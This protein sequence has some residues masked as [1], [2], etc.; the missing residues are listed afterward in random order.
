MGIVAAAQFEWIDVDRFGGLIEEA[1]ESV[2][3]LRPPRRAVCSS[4]YAVISNTLVPGAKAFALSVKASPSMGA[5][6][7]SETIR[8]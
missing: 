6:T 7:M 5:M 2:G 8:S 4:P 1:L 3:P